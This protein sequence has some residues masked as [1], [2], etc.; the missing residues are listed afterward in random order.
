MQKFLIYWVNINGD[1][2]YVGIY[3]YPIP[4]ENDVF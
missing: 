3:F 4:K 2:E 1:K